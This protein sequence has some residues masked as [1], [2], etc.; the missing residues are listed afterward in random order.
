MKK[1]FLFVTLLFTVSLL[2]AQ[3]AKV[4]EHK[5]NLTGPFNSPQEVTKACLE[6]HEE[7]G[8]QIIA[9]RHW[10]WAEAP[11][12]VPEGKVNLGKK[13]LINNFCIAVSSNYPRCTS[14]HIGYGWKDASFDFAKKENIDCLVCHDQT[15][16]YSKDPKGA[17]M[18]KEGIDLLNVAQN[19]GP[20]NRDNCGTCHFYGGG[21][22]AVKHGDMD[23]SLKNPTADFDVHMGGQDFSCSECHTAENHKIAGKSHGSRFMGTGTDVKCE[24][25]H[26]G[27][28]HKK[29]TLN[30]HAKTLACQT[31]HIPTY[32]KEIATKTWWDWST[33]GT[34]AV[35]K[36]DEFG[37]PDF[38]NKKGHFT[39]GKNLV[40]EYKWYNGSSGYYLLG[41]KIDASKAVE[42]N[43]L[44][45]T[46]ADKDAK[47][48]PFKVM[49]GKQP[50]DAERNII[51]IPKLFGKGGFW[52]SLKT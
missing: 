25:C 29:K 13:N 41:D 4:N 5:E 31:C 33:A 27:E 16:K 36:N 7:A 32:A 20:T 3:D 22:E 19:V 35:A 10:N 28:V 17:G 42:L 8:D 37:K 51:V 49:R 21:D 43:P 40:P 24:S 6:C 14:C 48:A 15:G 30:T 45:V 1:S 26:E 9:S 44:N 50:Y 18:P 11:G 23:G 12:S 47:I 34:R 52:A 2:F 39:R 38:I 46:I